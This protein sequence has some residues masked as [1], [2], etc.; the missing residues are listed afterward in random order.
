MRLVQ[1][2]FLGLRVY[3]DGRIRQIVRVVA[4]VL[5]DDFLVLELDGLKLLYLPLLVLDLVSLLE[6]QLSVLRPRLSITI[7]LKQLI[8]VLLHAVVHRLEFQ[9]CDL[10]LGLHVLREL[11]VRFNQSAQLP[12]VLISDLNFLQF[13]VFAE[14][15]LILP[16]L[17]LRVFQPMLEF[18]PQLPG[19]PSD[20]QLQVLALVEL[21]LKLRHEVFRDLRFLVALNF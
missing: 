11:V 20:G 1:I 18:V 16:K 10:E 14:F 3:S 15:L 12:L 9:L 17:V 2:L 19:L 13:H 6:D 5:V 7:Q 4:Q 8:I 21:E